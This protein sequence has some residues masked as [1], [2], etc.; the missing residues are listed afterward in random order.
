MAKRKKRRTT[1]V[2]LS[3]FLPELLLLKPASFSFL[4]KFFHLLHTVWLP[5]C[6]HLEKKNSNSPTF[7]I[8]YQQLSLPL[9]SRLQYVTSTTF[10]ASSISF[11]FCWPLFKQQRNL[12]LAPTKQSSDTATTHQDAAAG[13]QCLPHNISCL[14]YITNKRPLQHCV[15]KPFYFYLCPQTQ[16]DMWPLKGKLK[17]TKTK[18]KNTYNAGYVPCITVLIQSDYSKRLFQIKNDRL[19]KVI[20]KLPSTTPP[21]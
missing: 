20:P 9:S 7:H 4:L 12:G 3:S 11:P 17:K 2:Y 8:M 1:S 14:L 6:C 15:S 5:S 16:Q 18:P 19:K 21:D 10:P 13:T